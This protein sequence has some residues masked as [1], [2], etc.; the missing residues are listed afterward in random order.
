LIK[1]ERS[2]IYF[3][4]LDYF[5]FLQMQLIPSNSLKSLAV[6]QGACYNE[7]AILPQL[8]EL[9]VENAC[10]LLLVPTALIDYYFELSI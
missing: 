9:A 10:I 7:F 5:D 6:I 4:N 3:E 2:Q 8:S 1:L